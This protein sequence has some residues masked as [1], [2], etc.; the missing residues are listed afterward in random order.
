MQIRE[1]V[2]TFMHKTLFRVDSFTTKRREKNERTK[3]T[4]R[5]TYTDATWR[6]PWSGWTRSSDGELFFR[7]YHV[8]LLLLHVFFHFYFTWN[9]NE[10]KKKEDKIL[11]MSQKNSNQFFFFFFFFFRFSLRVLFPNWT[12]GRDK[13]SQTGKKPKAIFFSRSFFFFFFFFFI[14]SSKHLLCVFSFVSPSVCEALPRLG[15]QRNFYRKTN[16]NDFL[17]FCFVVD[18]A[19]SL[20]WTT[21]KSWSAMTMERWHS[22][23]ISKTQT[24]RKGIS[25][26]K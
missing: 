23:S 1:C 22:F 7:H 11:R 26:V 21:K 14:F 5:T 17:F 13:S 16:E 4:R 3:K 15:Y 9:N 25:T 10:G 18:D 8:L 19:V 12:N 20:L 6:E 2:L 24:N